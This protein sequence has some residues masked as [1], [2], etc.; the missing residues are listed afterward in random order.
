MGKDNKSG[1]EEII[2]L[3]E[4]PNISPAYKRFRL[5]GIV[6]E[7]L[8]KYRVRAIMVGG[9]AVELYSSQHYA[10]Q[11]IDFV[12]STN[13]RVTEC[14]NSL[15]FENHGGVWECEGTPFIIE[16]P[17]G[18]LAGDINR[19]RNVSIGDKIFT[20]IG[21]EDIIIDRCLRGKFWEA[22]PK[23]MGKNFREGYFSEWAKFMI[24]A[25]ADD[26]DWEYLKKRARE[27]DCEDVIRHFQK[28]YKKEL[29]SLDERHPKRQEIIGSQDFTDYL[30]KI[31]ETEVPKL[32]SRTSNYKTFV[33]FAKPILSLGVSWNHDDDILIVK[34]MCKY[35]LEKERI[36][37]CLKHSPN[38][39]GLSA[40][41]MTVK[42]NIIW[43]NAQDDPLSSSI[44]CSYI[45]KHS[46]KNK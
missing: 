42:A 26:L 35:D 9:S 11:D 44:V 39:L 16:F 17:K 31:I 22:S 4:N 8:A 24:E 13:E 21:A 14:M 15:G 41:E 34:N 12:L 46:C 6:C 3:A 32:S 30:N 43:K 18:P 29:S 1:R 27:E 23:I 40:K 20:V 2:E 37:E 45:K 33:Y 38:F 19:V 7:E 25:N 28:M 10:T 5:A 36:L